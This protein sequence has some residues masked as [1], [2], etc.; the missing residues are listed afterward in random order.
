MYELVVR[1]RLNHRALAD[2][3]IGGIRI[4]GGR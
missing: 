2:C 1:S 3:G 4:E